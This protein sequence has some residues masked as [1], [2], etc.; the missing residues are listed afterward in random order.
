MSDISKPTP[1]KTPFAFTVYKA[2]RKAVFKRDSFFGIIT[3]Y[4]EAYEPLPEGLYDKYS[5][6][7]HLAKKF[8]IYLM[9]HLNPAWSMELD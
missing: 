1:P 3:A 9:K 4:Q 7:R 5:R 2:H 8:H 6:Y